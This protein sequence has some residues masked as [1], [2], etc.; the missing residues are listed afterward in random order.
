[1]QGGV[2]Q[3]ATS[4]YAT[5]PDAS[6]SLTGPAIVIWLQVCPPS[7][8]DH[9]CGPKAQ[10]SD[11]VANRTL[12]IAFVNAAGTIPTLVHVLPASIDAARV[13]HDPEIQPWPH[14]APVHACAPSTNPCVADTN[15]TDAGRNPVSPAGVAGGGGVM[16]GA[17]EAGLVGEG[18]PA[19]A[20]DAAEVA[21]TDAGDDCEA[22]VAG[23]VPVVA[24]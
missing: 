6:T 20:D 21:G 10:P 17:L 22:E 24:A 2:P 12:V 7:C 5:P 3:L 1:M 16:T 8:V 4:T 11:A 23:A 9:S 19:L 15:V 14:D 18:D 13:A